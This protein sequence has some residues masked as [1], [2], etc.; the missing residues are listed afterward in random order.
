MSDTKKSVI[1][2]LGIVASVGAVY[3][4]L[5]VRQGTDLGVL[6]ASTKDAPVSRMLAS[7]SNDVNVPAADYFYELSQ[8]LKEQYVEPVSDDQ[9]LASGAIRGMISSLGDPDSVYMAKDQFKAFLNAREGKFEGIGADFVLSTKSHKPV[10]S[11]MSPSAGSELSPEDALVVVQEIP[12]VEVVNV[13]PGGPADKAGVKVG[14]TVDTVDGHWV[15]N[16]ELIRR[17]RVASKKFTD[18]KISKSELEALRAEVRIKFEKAIFPT[19]AREKLFLGKSGV[20]NVV[21][22]RGGVLRKS[23]IVRAISSLPPFGER[24][25]IIE[26]PFIDGTANQLKEAIKGKDSITIDLRNNTLG[27][28]QA[29][30]Q[31]LEVVAPK[32]EYGYFVTKRQESPTPLSVLKGNPHP[33]KIKLIVDDSTRG[34]AQVFAE[35]LSTKGLAT[36]KGEEPVGDRSSRQIVQLP[37]GAGYTLVTSEYEPTKAKALA[38]RKGG[39]K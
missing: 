26:L 13:V 10:Q 31:C 35:A 8:K 18:K 6:Q 32:G 9:K 38:F 4:G 37:D 28:V 1:A 15:V 12:K 14:D 36:L 7:R 39:A 30:K 3:G 16:S 11:S 29:M 23:S 17:F 19:K 21:W 25:G 27:D 22:N 20:V 2:A 5:K 33:P 24:A 34:M